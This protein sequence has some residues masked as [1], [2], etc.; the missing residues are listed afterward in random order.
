MALDFLLYYAR[1]EIGETDTGIC[2]HMEFIIDE[3]Y[4]IRIAR[5]IV[6]AENEAIYWYRLYN[7]R[8]QAQ[9][10]FKSGKLL[11]VYRDFTCIY[12]SN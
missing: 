12:F 6:K 5:L 7:S 2:F 9:S 1:L 11:L 10:L 3:R 4:G 8:P